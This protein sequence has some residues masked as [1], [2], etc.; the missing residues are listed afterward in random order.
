V[1]LALFILFRLSILLTS[2][3]KLYDFE[4]LYRGAIAKDILEGLSL[5]FFDYLYTDYEGGSI[6]EGL[7]ASP[8]F[9]LIGQTYF[10][11]KLVTFLI[12]ILIFSFW[13]Y[14]LNKFF[15]KLEA[16]VASLLIILSP[17]TYTKISLT[18]WGNHFES[19][20]FTITLIYLFYKVFSQDKFSKSV[21]FF[22]GVV[23]GL[24]TFF[25]YTFLISFA[26]VLFLWFVYD[27]RF[28]FRK[29]FLLFAIGYIIG[30]SPGIYFN[31]TH[32]FAGLYIKGVPIYEIFSTKS[33]S[34]D[35]FRHKFYQLVTF[36]M[37]NSFCFPSLGAI[38][39]RISNHIYYY[40]FILSYLLLLWFNR[41]TIYNFF[42][43][44]IYSKQL[45]KNH[46]IYSPIIFIFLFPIGFIIIS[47][48]APF[49]IGLN[50]NDY[51]W[52]RYLTPLLQ[53][54][55]III[56]LFISK[57]MRLGNEEKF[58]ILAKTFSSTLLAIIILIGFANNISLISFRKPINPFTYKGYNYFWL[59]QVVVYR[60]GFNLASSLPVSERVD[61]KYRP[62]YFE[63]LG[64]YYSW[65]FFDKKQ[66]G[67]ENLK[68]VDPILKS[69]FYRGLGISISELHG[70]NF[71]FKKLKE[72]VKENI[73][74]NQENNFYIGFG[75][76]MAFWDKKLIEKF[77]NGADRTLWKYFYQG[78]G[79]GLGTRLGFN[80][81]RFKEEAEKIKGDEKEYYYKGFYDGL[82]EAKF[83]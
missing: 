1:L 32:K 66:E 53:F 67:E 78:M 74:K 71:N 18:S 17:P 56:A 8:F 75:I 27:K 26:I 62:Q 54:E 76:M 79:R 59:G 24:G 39:G 42:L 30:F 82:R 14:F 48:L 11:L 7:L 49:K 69:S 25:T 80:E 36:H 63:G 52:Y 70:K 44:S 41:K 19:N 6:I 60:Y 68:R 22:M 28:I 58:N 45:K 83:I 64:Y 37:P 21:Y 16:A 23:S 38:S 77:L 47:S 65:A 29:S 20:L 3:D 12:S 2:I 46:E 57:I 50:P 51:F 61:K 72:F 35:N 81:W 31:L 40:I 73:E 10:S 43:A 9:S 34:G 55:I 5:P 15:G 33:T 13:Y 4:E